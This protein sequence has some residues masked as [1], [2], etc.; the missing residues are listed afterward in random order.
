ME[1]IRKIG[2]FSCIC[3]AMGIIV[4]A[5]IF[6]ALPVAV[7]PTGKGIALVA[8]VVFWDTYFFI[9]KTYLKKSGINLSAVMSADYQPWE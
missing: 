7:D 4:G 5:G 2:L 6:G 8:W 9:R 1:K 3:I